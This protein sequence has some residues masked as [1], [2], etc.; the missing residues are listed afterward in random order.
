MD[1]LEYYAGAAVRS[2]T[3]EF[4]VPAVLRA[5]AVV[6]WGPGSASARGGA[7]GG[8]PRPGTGHSPAPPLTRRNVLARDGGRCAY[9]GGAASTIDHVTPASKG[10]ARTWN[11]L[12]AACGPCNQRKGART[13]AQLGWALRA[14]PRRPAPHEWAASLAAAGRGDHPRGVG[15]GS[16]G[17]GHHPHPPPEWAAY[18]VTSAKAHR[19]GGVG[20][21][22]PDA[23][24]AAA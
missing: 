4:P 7:G 14:E 22:A 11:N 12:V 18:L 16:S 9:C 20:A 3:R 8:R 15:G 5:R 21:A 6:A 23:A 24:A 19:G 17:G 1:V 13:L 2:A 10:G